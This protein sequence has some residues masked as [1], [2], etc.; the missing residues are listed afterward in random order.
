M[1]IDPNYNNTDWNIYRLT[2]VYF[3][4]AE[5]LMRKAG[6][7]ATADA[8]ALINTTKSRAYAAADFVP[9]TTATLTMDELL[10]ERGREFI[11]EGFRRNDLIRFG[12]FTTASWWD[13]TPS[14]PFRNLMPIPQIQRTLNVNLTQNP[15]YPQ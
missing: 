6:N 11:F 4:K 10:A 15:G 7:V 3:A 13:H 2:W 1:P 14:Q 9:Y 8:V 12:K 5:A